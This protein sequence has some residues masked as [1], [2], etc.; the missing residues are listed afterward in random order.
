MKNL[1]LATSEAVEGHKA[2][3]ASIEIMT[4]IVKSIDDI[5]GKELV[6]DEVR[7]ESYEYP[8]TLADLILSDSVE[9]KK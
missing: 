3:G 6:D 7:E 9:I 2:V 1:A 8:R 4:R 5:L